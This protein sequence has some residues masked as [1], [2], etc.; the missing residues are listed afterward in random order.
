MGVY[1]TPALGSYANKPSSLFLFSPSMSTC[2]WNGRT[3]HS[4]HGHGTRQCR[5]P[6]DPGCLMCARI[7]TVVARTKKV[8]KK[9]KT[10]QDPHHPLHLHLP[11]RRQR[12]RSLTTTPEGSC[13]MPQTR[14]WFRR[15]RETVPH[16]CDLRVSLRAVLHTTMTTTMLMPLLLP[17]S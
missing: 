11:Q 15:W 4:A 10:N 5:L 3:I 6:N 14:W 12:H 1:S 2:G 17:R 9:T 7:S 13:P 16:R 8:M